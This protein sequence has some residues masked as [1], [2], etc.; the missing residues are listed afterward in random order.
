MEKV[1]LEKLGRV[2]TLFINRPA[3]FNAFDL[4]TL[5][6]MEEEAR[7]VEKDREMKVLLVRGKGRASAQGLT[8]RSEPFSII[9]PPTIPGR[10]SWHF[11]NSE[12][13]VFV[14]TFIACENI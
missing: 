6:E 10:G 1:I 7:L 3:A 8:W 14:G 4:D 12:S 5:S 9:S 2:A 13:Q 11:R